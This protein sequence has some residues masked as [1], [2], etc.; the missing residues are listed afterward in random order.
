MWPLLLTYHVGDVD[1]ELGSVNMKESMMAT[2]AGRKIATIN[3]VDK[4]N[5]LKMDVKLAR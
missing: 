3:E 5:V 1:Q 4:G 2:E